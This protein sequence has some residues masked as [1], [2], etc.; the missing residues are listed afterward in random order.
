EINFD[1]SLASHLNGDAACYEGGFG[2]DMRCELQSDGDG[3]FTVEQN[4]IAAGSGITVA[5]G[6][7]AGTV[8]QPPARLPNAATDIAP[9]PLGGGVLLLSLGGLLATKG[10]IRSRR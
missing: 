7:E 6:F 10:M 3:S 2:S 4:D 8:T 5:I 9:Y 1:D